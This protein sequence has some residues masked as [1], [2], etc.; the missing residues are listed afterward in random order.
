MP[1]STPPALRKINVKL[2]GLKRSR[3]LYDWRDVPDLADKL[4]NIL[5]DISRAELIS[6]DQ[7]LLV[8]EFYRCDKTVF[9][10]CDDSSGQIGEIFRYSAKDLFWNIASRILD[11]SLI[12]SVIS[13]LLQENQ[14]GAR[15]TLLDDV[16]GLLSPDEIRI[17]IDLLWKIYKQKPAKKNEYSDYLHGIRTLAGQIPD[18][19]LYEKI[20]KKISPDLNLFDILRISEVYL[21]SG[22][23]EKALEWIETFTIDR[24]YL[25]KEYLNLLFS[26]YKKLGLTDE[27]LETAWRL[28]RN[29]PDMDNFELIVGETGESERGRLISELKDEFLR[30][31][32]FSYDRARF[33]I[34]CGGVEEAGE[35]IIARRTELDGKD[36]STL[37]DFTKVLEKRGLFLPAC[38]IYR[39]LLESI[40]ARTIS[41]YYPFA[42]RYLR[43]LDKISPLVSD[44]R[45]IVP[46]T[47]Y[48][49]E[50]SEK[51]RLKIKFW[52]LYSG[53]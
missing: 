22:Q 37:L 3:K 29:K 46:H 5:D 11:K 25:L 39:T 44:W 15:D 36:Y 52:S 13:D 38:V 26:I 53:E 30:I 9:E 14:Y 16:E 27:A 48:L 17:L 7:I 19:E 50:L 33:L 18:P 40:L 51:H 1:K 31:P 2:A 4:N 45:D 10:N 28:F 8:E 23:A 34:D 20:C 21:N 49:N 35:Y 6:E 12:F 47:E 41:K 24:D 43:K 32:E 42:V